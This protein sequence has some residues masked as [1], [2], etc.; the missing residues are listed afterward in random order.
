MK[1][2]EWFDIFG[3]KHRRIIESLPGLE[4][5]DLIGFFRYENMRREHPEFCPL[6]REGEKCHDMDDLNCYLC[7]CPHFRFCDE[8]IDVINGKIRYSLCAIDATA[9]KVVET[10]KGIHQDCSDCLLPHHHGFIRKHFD[11]KWNKIMEKCKTCA[12]SV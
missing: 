12:S 2:G 6:Y 10:G 9:G 11:R 7:A 3:E 8:G 5:N 4:K 1:Y